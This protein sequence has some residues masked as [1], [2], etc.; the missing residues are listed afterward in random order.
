MNLRNV[1]FLL[2]FML[3]G[4]VSFYG[5]EKLSVEGAIILS[6][7][8][9]ATPEAGTIRWTGTD[10]E[11]WTGSNWISLSL[12]PCGGLTFVQ[13]VDANRY[14]IVSIGTQCWMTDNL[15]AV[16]FNDGT[17]IQKLELDTSWSTVLDPAYSWYD[18]MAS[19]ANPYGALYN[20]YTVASASN[21]NKN[22]CPFGW[23]VP[24]EQDILDLVNSLGGESIAGIPLKEA[25]NVHF[26]ESNETANN[27]SGFTAMPG[28]YRSTASYNELEY[29]AQYWSSTATSSTTAIFLDIQYD[30]DYANVSGQ[31]KFRGNSVRCLKD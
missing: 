21:G 3:A 9:D 8:E 2:V 27:L 24:T 19:N 25:G 26:V 14:R 7:S 13:D 16:N 17:P 20:W 11:G 29:Y 6:N 15:R 18:D 31:S 23:H 12:G 5:Q 28:G 1:T 22:V 10:F 4:C 30:G